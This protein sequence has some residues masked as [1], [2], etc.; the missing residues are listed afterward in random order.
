MLVSIPSKY[1]VSQVMGHLNVK[2]NLM[3]VDKYT[4]M[5]CQ[6]FL[7]IVLSCF[8]IAES[9]FAKLFVDSRGGVNTPMFCVEKIES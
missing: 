2:S 4:N 8:L 7:Q 6:F 3:I 1:N 5:R 9:L